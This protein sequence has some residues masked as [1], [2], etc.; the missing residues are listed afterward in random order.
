MNSNQHIL[1]V[2]DEK[3][4]RDLIAKLLQKSGFQTHIAED[5]LDAMSAI[6]E[7]LPD[8]IITDF[9][10]PRM[11]GIEFL[12]RIWETYPNMPVIFMSA[13]YNFPEDLAPIHQGQTHFLPKPIDCEKLVQLC[14][15]LL[16]Q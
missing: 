14:Q 6:E 1:I 11:D 12:A 9:K 4:V 16:T 3:S 10:M 7:N 8:L 13:Y 5:G 15:K 2:D